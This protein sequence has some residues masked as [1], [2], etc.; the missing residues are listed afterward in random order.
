MGSV[1]IVLAAGKG[2]RMK[3]ERPKALHPLWGLP[4]VAYVLRAFEEATIHPLIVVI[5]HQADSVR[6]ALGDQYWYALQTEPLGTGHACLQAAPLLGYQVPAGVDLSIASF[7]GSPY[8]G[9]VIVAPGDS[10]LVTSEALQSLLEHH[11]RTGAV[12]TI[13]TAELE[14]PTGYGRI[15]RDSEGKVI[16]IVEEKDATAEQ[17]RLREVCTSFYCF[18]APALFEMLPRLSNQNVQGEYYLTDVIALL[19]QAGARVETWLSPDPTLLMG[20]NNRWELAQAGRVLRERF[21]RHLALEGVTIVDPASTYV[22]ATVKVGAETVIEPNCYLRGQTTIGS[23]C[24]IGPET[25]L[26]DTRVGDRCVILRSHV[27]G[28]EIESDVRVGPFAQLRPGTLLR[29]GARVGNFV[30]IKASEIGEGTK[31][32]HLTYIGDASVGAETNIGAGTITCNY[33]GKRKHRTVIGKG[34]FVGSHATLIAPVTIGDG[35]YIA[36]ASP[37]NQDVPPDALAIAR[38]YQTNKEGWAK[39]RREQ[40]Q[41]K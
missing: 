27:V 20:V 18:Q 25:F 3:S 1:G 21:L 6:A 13:A 11:R 9:T 5:G 40:D 10:P 19:A 30:E 32:M 38:S 29:S 33:D 28:C 31:V 16:G 14:N 24:V 15:L 7:Q 22:D 34:V 8:E 23:D 17:K 12:A 26:Q 4:L 41:E 36:A 39:R 2:T 37:I 35:A